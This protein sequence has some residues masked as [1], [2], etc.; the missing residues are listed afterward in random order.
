MPGVT[1]IS[2]PYF[3]ARPD[4][5][6]RGAGIVVIH[7]G[8]GM[9]PQ[10]LRYCERLAHEGYSVVAPDLFYRV[11]GPEA[12]DF[13]TLIGS[14]DAVTT[15]ADLNSMATGLRADGAA[16]VGVTGFCMGGRWTWRSAVW[17]EGFDAGVGFYGGGIAQDLG[18]PTIPTLLFFGGQ[19]PWV[20]MTD[21]EA[22]QAHHPDTIVYAEAGHGFMRDGSESY[23]PASAE[24]AWGKMLAFFADHLS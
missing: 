18:T 23:H 6:G 4:G 16:K 22:V 7:E 1:H 3:S 2:L 8:G 14:L 15:Q 17:G 20:P 10:L 21:I 19:D 24:D 5:A 11:G 12:A 9:S 13:G